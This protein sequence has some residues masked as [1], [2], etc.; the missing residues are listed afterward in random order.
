[1]VMKLIVSRIDKSL[2]IP[3]YET[4]GAAAFDICARVE[5]VVAPHEL[6]FVPG[7]LVVQVP[8]GHVLLL[9]SRSSTP[10]K[11]GLLTPHGLGVIDR[12][13]S[14][15]E[16]ELIVQV[17]NFTDVPIT[18]ARGERIAQALVVPAP[19][20]ELVEIEAVDGASRGGF[21]STG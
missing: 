15:P 21:G 14:G 10:K 7:N 6:G 8:E 9:A 16:D 4:A 19:R 1:M 5:T 20:L 12:D 13:Y 18:V 17:W 2:P 3:C 11:K